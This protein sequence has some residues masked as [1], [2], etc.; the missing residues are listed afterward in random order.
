[1]PDRTKQEFDALAALIQNFRFRCE[2]RRH[3]AQNGLIRVSHDFSKGS[4]YTLRPQAARLARFLGHNS[5]SVIIADPALAFWLQSFPARAD[6]DACISI[7][8]EL[9]FCEEPLSDSGAAE[10]LWDMR[11]HTSGLTLFDV[12]NLVVTPVS[13]DIDLINAQVF[14]RGVG[15]LSQQ[16]QV[17][18]FVMNLLL[19]DQFVLCINGDLN[20]VTNP[21]AT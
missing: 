8:L 7:I 19:C 14:P 20:V 5:G 12:F 17:A 2:P 21:N 4:I 9:L 11:R 16:S 13:D 3:P 15:C 1:M 10:R 6:Q 18:D